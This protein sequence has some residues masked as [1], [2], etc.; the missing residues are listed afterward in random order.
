MNEYQE[1]YTMTMEEILAVQSLAGKKMLLGFSY[2]AS[3]EALWSACCRLQAQG[4]LQWEGDRMV[5]GERL[6]Q[7]M[8]PVFAAHTLLVLTPGDDLKPQTLY[9]VADQVT[10]LEANAWG[11]YNLTTWQIDELA[12]VLEQKLDLRY[13]P[14]PVEDS[15]GE[16]LPSHLDSVQQLRNHALFV[17]EQFDAQSGERQQ[18]LR[19]LDS[20][21]NPWL[22]WCRGREVSR[23]TM[24]QE[25]FTQV[26][27]DY[28][29]G[30]MEE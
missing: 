6:R 10:Q 16:Q 29:K 20:A 17:L 18:W 1:Q 24:T 26:L 8:R 28:L 12:D 9:Y 30:G 3:E 13:Y 14:I 19:G 7:V 5:P 22:E 15:D 4:E 23:N 25:C 11:S 2:Q 21:V 27:A